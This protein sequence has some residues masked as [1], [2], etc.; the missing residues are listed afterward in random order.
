MVD[1]DKWCVRDAYKNAHM[2]YSV[3][4]HEYQLV[5]RIQ[6]IWVCVQCVQSDCEVLW[7]MQR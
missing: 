3:V 4:L 5:M 7:D 2:M 1:A 6:T